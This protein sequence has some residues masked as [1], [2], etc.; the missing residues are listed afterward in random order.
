MFQFT[1]SIDNSFSGDLQSS[2]KLLI[3]AGKDDLNLSASMIN[4]VLMGSHNESPVKIANS[5][6][7]NPLDASASDEDTVVQHQEAFHGSPKSGVFRINEGFR[8]YLRS[9][10]I[11]VP[12]NVIESQ[13]ALAQMF[14]LQN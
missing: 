12:Q 8:N 10:R 7:D 14:N 1:H 5:S 6:T 11:I 3:E 9:K 2:K 13:G 4:P